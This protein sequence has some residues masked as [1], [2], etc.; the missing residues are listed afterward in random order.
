MHLRHRLQDGH[1]R[2]H[3]QGGDQER[4]GEE[5]GREQALLNQVEGLFGAHWIPETMP[6][7]SRP[8]PSIN[9]KTISLKGSEITTGGSIIMP[10]PRSCLLYTSPSPRD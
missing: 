8:Q 7:T 1:D 6:V 4:A 9:T 3:E 10:M 5:H 2:T